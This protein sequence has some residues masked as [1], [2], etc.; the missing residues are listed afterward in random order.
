MYVQLMSTTSHVHRT[1]SKEEKNHFITN[2]K[3]RIEVLD[4]YHPNSIEPLSGCTGT[5]M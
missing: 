4:A 5:Y 2:M 3:F 1:I